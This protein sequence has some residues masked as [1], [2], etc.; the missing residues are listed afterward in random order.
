MAAR[1]AT[2]DGF[3]ARAGTLTLLFIAGSASYETLLEMLESARS[4]GLL[5]PRG[6]DWPREDELEDFEDEFDDDA[7]GGDLDPDWL[8]DP[9]TL[10][11]TSSKGEQ[12]LFVAF[13]LER[14]LRNCPEGPLAIGAE[15]TRV[16]APLVFG[17][18]ATVTHAL[19][20][21][22]LTMAE[23]DRA[24]GILSYEAL[25]EHVEAME[26]AGLIEAVTEGG[27]TRYRVTDWMREGTAPIAAA[28]RVERHYPE[29]DIAPPDVLDVEAAFQLTLP[30]LRLPGELSGA[31][32]LG[33]QI[34]GGPPLMAGATVQV[35]GGSVVFSS[36]L[37]EDEA[38][39]FA[40]G[41]PVDWLDTLVDPSAGRVKAGGDTRLADALL[42]GLHEAVFG[43]RIR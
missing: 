34:P 28:A 12:M 7:S 35:E 5:R 14:W 3:R 4:G 33:V 2:G 31:C 38:E 27:E 11:R 20:R 32:R 37:L 22:P 43:V 21:E 30:L 42:E 15:A 41:S 16:F 17:W 1:E 29:A 36:A 39:T 10:M 19:A 25:E 18:S 9:H 24:V 13:T 6:D 23:L 26:A 40:T 8:D